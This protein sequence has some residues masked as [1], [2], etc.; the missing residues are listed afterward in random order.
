MGSDTEGK[1]GEA[2]P[3]LQWTLVKDGLRE[4]LVDTFPIASKMFLYGNVPSGFFVIFWILVLA[5]S[6][7]RLAQADRIPERA[8]ALNYHY[9][10]P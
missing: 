6:N 10:L 3:Q 2:H 5:L 9:E 4:Q 1:G 7:G 8:L